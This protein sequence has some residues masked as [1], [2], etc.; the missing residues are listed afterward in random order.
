MTAELLKT[1]E[2]VTTVPADSGAIVAMI[3]YK[4]T[5]L[6]ACQYCV[7]QLTPDNHF[8]KITFEEVV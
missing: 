8:K 4:D 1:T 2:Y 6:L 5:I 7:Y 3:Q